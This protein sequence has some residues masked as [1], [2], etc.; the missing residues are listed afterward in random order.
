[1]RDSWCYRRQ[2]A[3]TPSGGPHWFEAL[4]DFV[5]PAYLRYSFTKG[6]DQEVAFLVD[7]LGLGPGARVLDVG[8]GP[9]RHAYALAAAGCEVVGVDI[10]ER[11]VHLAAA[12]APPGARFVRA[13]ARRLPVR[14]GFDAAV[15]LCQ[16]GFGLP[17]RPDAPDDAGILREMAAALRPGGRL[18]LSAFSSYFLV[19]HL[20]HSDDFDVAHGVNREG[21]TVRNEAGEEQTFDLWTACYTPR[22]LR[23]LAD[24]AGLRVLGLWSVT[25]GRYDRRPPDLE[26][27]ELLLLAERSATGSV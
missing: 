24:A 26:H 6:T 9:G 18:A 13:D 1:L 17:S 12:G 27:P 3:Q 7:V 22:E 21:S 20:E 14:P 5:G 10:A 16:G 4:A 23:L 15:S 2:I 8:C 11:F 19:R 25:P